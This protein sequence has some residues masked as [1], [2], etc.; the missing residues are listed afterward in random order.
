MEL[1]TKIDFDLENTP[2]EIK[3]ESALGSDEIMKVRFFSANQEI[4]GGIFLEFSSSPT[5]RIFNCKSFSINPTDF[6]TN[7]IKIWRITLSR[8]FGKQRLVVH[9]ND[10]EVLNHVI[11]ETKC[12]DV[13]WSSK[14]GEKIV[15]IRFH[16]DDTASVQYR[17]EPGLLLDELYQ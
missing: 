13:S 12:D 2:L 6:P 14:W 10:A 7:I 11:S 3:T 9:C 4:A 5:F 15:K 16:D 17:T 8:N 1:G